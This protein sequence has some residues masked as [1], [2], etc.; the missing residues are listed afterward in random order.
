[1]KKKV[2]IVGGVAGG[3]SAAARLRRLSEE[4]EIV[5]F[6]KGENISFANCGLPY[7]IGDVIKNREALLLMTP[8]KM[9]AR[10]DID[11]RV[12]SCIIGVDSKNN[13]VEV[14]T[15]D[16]KRYKEGY[17]F[18]VLAPGAKPVV[19]PIKGIESE[20]IY[21][22]RNVKDMDRIKNKALEIEGKKAAVIGGG[23]VGIESAENLK[24]LGL[25]VSLVEAMDSILSPYDKEMAEFLELELKRN[26]VNVKTNTKVVE[27]VE[28][29][30]GI[31]IIYENGEKESVDMVVLAIGVTPDTE[32]L[33]G[34][35]ID[36]GKKG[37]ILVDEKL[38]TNVE[39]I[40]A[41]GDAIVVKN[42]VTMQDS[43]IPLAGPANKHGRVVANNIAGK[44]EKYKES[45]GTSIIK[46]FNMV[47]ASTGLNEKTVKGLGREYKKI[48]LNPND[49]ANYYP[50]ATP[51]T[52]KIV[53]DA[54][55]E[56]ILGGQVIG[57]NGVDKVID[58]LATVIKFRGT[59]EDL[60]E[61][62]LAYAPPFNSPKS[63]LNM[64]GFIAENLKEGMFEQIFI[65]DLK[66]YDKDR[67]I[68]VDVREKFELVVGHLENDINIPLSELRKRVDEL[69]KDKEIWVYCAIGL[70]GYIASRFLSQKGYK[71]KNIAGGYKMKK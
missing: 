6:E 11:V 28:K 15:L 60:I 44:E 36:L 47:G 62:E 68:I 65:E 17:D 52:I 48:Y 18:L 1:M 67:N 16:G 40:Y 22:L 35:G 53:Y 29:N 14:E 38:R 37:D 49:H 59:M 42:L 32:F 27:F 66:N 7:F 2:V 70:R 39:N 34:S 33:K 25:E 3:A 56:E 61:L 58:V 19:P 20:K 30:D 10:F 54:K 8:E 4:F 41:V 13:E 43:Y 57:V 31:E 9:K 45:L 64:A 5:L 12:K 51:L 24:H 69:P 26:G 23:F 46:V 55:T 21:T 63:P 71:V 50:G